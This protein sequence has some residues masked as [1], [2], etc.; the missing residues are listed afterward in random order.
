MSEENKKQ[1]QGQAQPGGPPMTRPVAKAKDF[2]W[3]IKKA[4]KIFDAA[5]V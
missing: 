4:Y 5:K 2:F 3:N 1:P